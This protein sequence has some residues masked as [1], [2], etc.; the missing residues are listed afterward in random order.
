MSIISLGSLSGTRAVEIEETSSFMPTTINNTAKTKNRIP[1]I[2]TA[3]L[4]NGI[5]SERSR[6]KIFFQKYKLLRATLK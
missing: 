6:R 1:N 3:N 5:F 4:P 2:G